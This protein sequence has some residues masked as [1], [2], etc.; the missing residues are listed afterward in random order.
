MCEAG[1]NLDE[2]VAVCDP[3]PLVI[4]HNGIVAGRLRVDIHADGLAPRDLERSLELMDY[5]RRIRRCGGE[6]G[7]NNDEDED[8]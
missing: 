2:L 3:R 8:E 7:E 4:I 5:N 6:G 1:T